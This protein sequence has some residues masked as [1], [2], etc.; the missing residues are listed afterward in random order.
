M[1]D[2]DMVHQIITNICD[3]SCHTCGYNICNIDLFCGYVCPDEME[4][5]AK[6]HYHSRCCPKKNH[7]IT[8]NG[9]QLDYDDD[10][11]DK[12]HMNPKIGKAF[13]L[14]MSPHPRTAL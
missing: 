12:A 6:V 4:A 5:L 9:K 13:S 3:L 1:T 11:W 10:Q 14:N 7:H 8:L 2:L